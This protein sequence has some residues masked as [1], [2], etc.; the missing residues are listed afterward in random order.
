MIEGLAKA[1]MRH[2]TFDCGE[3]DIQPLDLAEFRSLLLVP[4][5]FSKKSSSS[6]YK[7]LIPG[8]TTSTPISFYLPIFTLFWALV[9]MRWCTASWQTMS[10]SRAN[11]NSEK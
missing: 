8:N 5:N 6:L 3:E 10:M 7:D 1:A 9:E 4:P 11:L 2:E